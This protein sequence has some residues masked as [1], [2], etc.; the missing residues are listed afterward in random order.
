[1]GLDNSASIYENRQYLDDKALDAFKICC[2]QFQGG[3]CGKS[4]YTIIMTMTG[5]SLYHIIDP[6][7]C[8]NISDKISIFF[9]NNDVKEKKKNFMILTYAITMMIIM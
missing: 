5:T 8:K 2:H 4:Y 7:E 1:M 3:F 6:E 9:K